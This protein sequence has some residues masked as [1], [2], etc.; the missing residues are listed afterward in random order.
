MQMTTN[1][2]DGLDVDLRGGL[3]SVRLTIAF[4]GFPADALTSFR[5]SVEDCRRS[6]TLQAG[7][8]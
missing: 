5:Y 1:Y 7:N 2:T 4:F 3:K 8:S 6:T